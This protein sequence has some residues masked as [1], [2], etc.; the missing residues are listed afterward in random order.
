LPLDEA[1]ELPTVS[2][3]REGSPAGVAAVGPRVLVRAPVVAVVVVV[4]MLVTL[5][6]G[7]ARLEGDMK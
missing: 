2:D 4:R 3:R 1:D 7:V 6:N 5:G